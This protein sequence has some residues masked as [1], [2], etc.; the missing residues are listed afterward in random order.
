MYYNPAATR[1]LRIARI[2]SRVSSV[3]ISGGGKVPTFAMFSV[4]AM[5]ASTAFPTSSVTVLAISALE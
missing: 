4:S 3:C 5:A 2:I 1:A